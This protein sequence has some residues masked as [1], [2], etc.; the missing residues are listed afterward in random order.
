M[1]EVPGSV[2]LDL[3]A[4]RQGLNVHVAAEG[5]LREI[6]N[7]E[8]ERLGNH[9]ELF[10]AS[11]KEANGILRFSRVGSDMQSGQ[12]LVLASFECGVRCGSKFLVLMQRKGNAWNIVGDHRVPMP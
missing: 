11:Y 2:R 3:N 9:W 7:Y 8:N 4:L 6:F 10:K 1:G 5:K 12:A